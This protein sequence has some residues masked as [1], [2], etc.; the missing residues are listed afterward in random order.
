MFLQSEVFASGLLEKMRVF[1]IITRSG[2]NRQSTYFNKKCYHS[3]RY[4]ILIIL[5]RLFTHLFK[6][7]VKSR[8]YLK[9]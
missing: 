7:K 3:Q 9:Y 6:D 4:E 8:V 1:V 2:Y 5:K